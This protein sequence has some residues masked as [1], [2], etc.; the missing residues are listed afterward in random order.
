MDGIDRLNL[1]I[2]PYTV[3]ELRGYDYI[4]NPDDAVADVLDRFKVNVD[5]PGVLIIQDRIC[6][7]MVSRRKCYEQLSRPFGLEVYL[8]RK[9]INLHEHIATNHLSVP[10]SMYINEAVQLGLQREKDLIYEPIIVYHQEERIELLDMH[11]LLLAQSQLLSSANKIIKQQIDLERSLSSTLD[12]K[13]ILNLVLEKIGEIIPHS[14]SIVLLAS[15]GIIDEMAVRG[16]PQ[17]LSLQS[18]SEQFLHSDIYAQ[19]SQNRMPVLIRCEDDVPQWSFI[20]SSS[21][22][23]SL[24]SVPLIHSSKIYGAITIV[25]PCHER[26]T[27]LTLNKDHPS[28][29]FNQPVSNGHFTRIDVERLTNISNTVSVAIRNAQLYSETQDLAVKDT[30]TRVYNRRGF[31]ELAQKKVDFA[32]SHNRSLTALMVDVD[33]FKRVNDTYGH[34]AGDYV[35]QRIAEECKNAIRDQDLMG[36]YGGEEFIILLPDSN[37]DTAEMIAERLLKRIA[38]MVVKTERHSISVTVSIGIA[39]FNPQWESLDT[40]FE[41]ADKALYTAKKR[42]RNSVVV[43]DPLVTAQNNLGEDAKD[44]DTASHLSQDDKGKLNLNEAYDGMI[45]GWVRTLEMRDKETEGHTQRV[46]E[47]T[48]ML[49]EKYGVPEEELAHIR[50]GALL[51]DIGKIAIP[52]TILFKP[53]KLTEDEWEI[54]RRHPVYAFELLEAYDFLKPAIHIPY[55]HHEKWDGSGYPQGI[56]GKKIPLAARLFAIV[57]VWDALRSDR[58][59]RPAWPEQEVIEYLVSN[60]GIHFDPEVVQA[61]LE[62]LEEQSEFSLVGSV[63]LETP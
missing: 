19:I 2:L 55:C 25:R 53:G 23:Y 44:L 9:I 26:Q 36:R 46:T 57:D 49:A 62:L 16:L 63:H 14:Q 38:G 20:D 15:N 10:A 13:Q 8:K 7:G 21:M 29:H 42:G 39:A 37:L 52:D 11:T 3:G 32:R 18:I 28:G 58:I 22:Q 48:L 47:I 35:L 61:F 1:S 59:Y 5:L 40:L 12:M 17:D 34:A 33:H 54:M 30:L 56:E 4:V 27:D 6:L 24:L 45:E 31:F 41:C 60:A 50:R 51:H 43:W